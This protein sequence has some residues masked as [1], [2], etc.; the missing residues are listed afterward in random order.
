MLLLMHSQSCQQIHEV[1]FDPIALTQHEQFQHHLNGQ[2]VQHE[3][4]EY[5]FCV[6]VIRA[7]AKQE[8]FSKSYE[9]IFSV[10]QVLQYMLKD[11]LHFEKYVI[12]GAGTP[13]LEYLYML[14]E[15]LQ[16][17]SDMDLVRTMY[18]VLVNVCVKQSL[19]GHAGGLELEKGVLSLYVHGL[20][21]M[22]LAYAHAT[23]QEQIVLLTTYF[24]LQIALQLY[25]VDA[26]EKVQMVL[27]QL[28]AS[29]SQAYVQKAHTVY[30][31][32]QKRVKEYAQ[33][34]GLHIE[35]E[36]ANMHGDAYHMQQIHCILYP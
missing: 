16:Y 10:Q 31:G 34:E 4:L 30:G 33:E 12:N 3:A 24:Y 8:L 26:H 21:C 15:K 22:L 13:W 28:V 20:V 17:A 6:R 9:M 29:A 23:I 19:I 11:F 1:M 2:I 25:V 14:K 36:H 35:K 32:P 5:D 27:D 18:Q 7:K